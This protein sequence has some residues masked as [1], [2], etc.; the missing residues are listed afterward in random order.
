MKAHEIMTPRPDVVTPADPLSRAAAIMRDRDVG[1]VP[2][3]ADTASMMLEGV[4]TDRDVAVRHVADEH[5]NDCTVGRHMSRENIQAV[6][7]S[8]DVASV[9]AA[10]ERAEVRRVPVTDAQGKLIGVIAQADVARCDVIPTALV[11]EVVKKVS[12][13]KRS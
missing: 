12:E 5:G 10:M 13:P 2:V 7:E 1:M 3:V 11:A 6:T 9:I 8:D 4:I